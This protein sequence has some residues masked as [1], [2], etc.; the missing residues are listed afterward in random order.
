MICARIA[1][2]TKG[3]MILEEEVDYLILEIDAILWFLWAEN[4]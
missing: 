3:K 1:P 4:N 2:F